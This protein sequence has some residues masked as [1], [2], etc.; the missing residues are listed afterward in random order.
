M[1]LTRDYLD[2]LTIT[3]TAESASQQQNASVA[4]LTVTDRYS[5][6]PGCLSR[7]CPEAVT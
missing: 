3:G 1:L 6:G 5:R 7:G 4:Q 2:W